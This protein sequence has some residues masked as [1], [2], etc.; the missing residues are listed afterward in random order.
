MPLWCYKPHR[1]VAV[2][3][4]FLSSNPAF[5]R[6]LVSNDEWFL[7]ANEG[8]VARFTQGDLPAV[9]ARKI[10]LVLCMDARL[11]PDKFLG[12]EVGD[13][14]VIRNA[15]GRAADAIRSL[16]ISQQFLG[17][18]EIAVIHHTDCGMLAFREEQLHQKLHD[19][20]RVRADIEFLPFTDLEQ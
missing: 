6:G 7:K 2:V 19:E 9:P 16:V 15:G 4:S 20:L 1:S 13:A 12:L 8:Y 14:N 17:T 11:D 10:A 18:R 5:R 3:R